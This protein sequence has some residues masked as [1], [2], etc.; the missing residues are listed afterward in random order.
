MYAILRVN[1]YDPEKLAA[2]ADRLEE[3]DQL[4]AAQPGAEGSIGV[5]LG[6]GRRFVLNLWDGV[7]SSRAGQRVLVPHLQ[8]LLVPLMSQPS[9]FLGAGPVITWQMAPSVGG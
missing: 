8:R 2:A 7:E 5:D 4:H 1:T 3:F 6:E 9:Q